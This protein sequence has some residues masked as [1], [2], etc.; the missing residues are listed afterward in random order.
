MIRGFESDYYLMEL[1]YI[2][3]VK[4]SVEACRFNIWKMPR[5]FDRC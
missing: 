2:V 1:F 5:V 3:Y 4:L